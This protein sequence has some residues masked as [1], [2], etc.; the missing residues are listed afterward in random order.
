MTKDIKNMDIVSEKIQQLCQYASQE[1]VY[2]QKMFAE[3][4]IDAASFKTERD[5]YRIPFLSKEIIQKERGQLLALPYQRYPK[6]NHLIEERSVGNQG[7]YLKTFWSDV[8]Y[9][10]AQDILDEQRY[11]IFGVDN[12]Q[13]YCCFH[14][15]SYKDNLIIE[16]APII[17][18]HLVCSI[19]NNGLAGEDISQVYD[20]LM[21]FSPSYLVMQPSI[22]YQIA[23]YI[24]SKSLT[25]PDKLRY[26]ELTGEELS[27]QYRSFIQSVFNI[28]PTNSYSMKGL[29]YIAHEC[30]R[31]HMHVLADNVYVEVIKNGSP[32]FDEIGEVVVTSLT[33][34]AMP[35]I[36]YKT[37]DFGALSMQE[38]AC[39][40]KSPVLKILSGRVA[41][42]IPLNSTDFL[43]KY[44]I[45][46][47][48]EYT[49]E[50]ISNA[51]SQFKIEHDGLS[52]TVTHRLKPAYH[53]WEKAV[54]KE[55]YETMK[56][57]CYKDFQAIRWNHVFV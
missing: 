52:I 51:V 13:K 25:A 21:D 34:Y 26:I 55:F 47:L 30:K 17:S 28:C 53:G 44:A 3:N 5:F 41:G 27:D 48:L 12:E 1:V 2:Y 6:I 40:N 15:A 43:N 23:S 57:D 42:F 8:D 36:R 33:N 49:N 38:C 56:K 11:G 45:K 10:K 19:H 20:I 4:E 18:N 16:P 14:T 24:N 29:H 46:G 39:G 50:F 54:E 7:F 32:V 37:G 35:M 22:A 9:Q 31:G